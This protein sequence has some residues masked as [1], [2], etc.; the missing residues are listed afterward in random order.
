MFYGAPTRNDF[1]SDFLIWFTGATPVE[2]TIAIFFS[3]VQCR[4]ILLTRYVFPVPA[5]PLI[6]KLWQLDRRNANSWSSSSIFRGQFVPLTSY[7]FVVP[8]YTRNFSAKRGVIFL[9]I[10]GTNAFT[11]VGFRLI[12]SKHGH[13]SVKIVPY[14]P[15][16]VSYVHDMRMVSERNNRATR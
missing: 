16:N 4:T 9:A 1:P 14:H 10:G 2:H 7:L 13:L 8:M 12:G 15:I 11:S 5:C 6:I 3:F